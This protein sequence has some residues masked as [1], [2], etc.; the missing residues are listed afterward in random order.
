MLCSSVS[1]RGESQCFILSTGH[2][3]RRPDS[4]PVGI[5]S[6]V[7]HPDQEPVTAG[8]P[9]AERVLLLHHGGHQQAENQAGPRRMTLSKSLTFH[10]KA[11]KKKKIPDISMFHTQWMKFTGSLNFVL[12]NDLI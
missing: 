4:D 6:N 12:V 3:P 11:G 8:A 10:S 9:G 1:F 2:V 7:W 5:G